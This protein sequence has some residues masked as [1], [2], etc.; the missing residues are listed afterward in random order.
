[1]PKWLLIK[2]RWKGKNNILIE[3]LYND[4]LKQLSLNGL[5]K[6]HGQTLRD[7]AKQVDEKF[8]T[9]HM[10]IL[11]QAY[12]ETLYSK[13]EPTIDKDKMIECWKYLINHLGG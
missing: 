4:L 1:M 5:S 7:F 3:P 9:E 8:G 10:S 6:A 11:T 2:Y 12:E 13:E